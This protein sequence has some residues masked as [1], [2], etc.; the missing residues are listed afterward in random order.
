MGGGENWEQKVRIAPN[1]PRELGIPLSSVTGV[2]AMPR[3][4]PFRTAAPFGG[5]TTWIFE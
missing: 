1:P 5:Q 3:V 4:N 2:S